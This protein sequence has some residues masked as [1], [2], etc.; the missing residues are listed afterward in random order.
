MES[1]VIQPQVASVDVCAAVYSSRMLA[2]NVT[3]VRIEQMPSWTCA[4]IKIPTPSGPWE[5]C[6]Q[7]VLHERDVLSSVQNIA[8]L[9]MNVQPLKC[10]TLLRS[11]TVMAI[12]RWY[13]YR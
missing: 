3:P 11:V 13:L 10:P 7:F 6:V 4:K 8:R 5:E 2:L 9:I 12:N 1:P